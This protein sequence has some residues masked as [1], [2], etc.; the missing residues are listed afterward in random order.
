[1]YTI[2]LFIVIDFMWGPFGK[3]GIWRSVRKVIVVSFKV[4]SWTALVM[5]PTDLFLTPC[6]FILQKIKLNMLR[7]IQVEI[8]ASYIRW[9]KNHNSLL[10]VWGLKVERSHSLRAD[11]FIALT[12]VRNFMSAVTLYL[13]KLYVTDRQRMNI[14][15]LGH[16]SNLINKHIFF[17]IARQ[18]SKLKFW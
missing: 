11:G 16:S 7:K 5:A 18:W 13:V 1:M 12:F 4:F 17:S 2:Q 9:K 8:S 6:P 3:E 10:H 14:K 15:G